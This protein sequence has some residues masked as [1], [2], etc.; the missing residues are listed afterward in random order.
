ML[1]ARSTTNSRESIWDDKSP[2]SVLRSAGSL[3]RRAGSATIAQSVAGS[4]TP[5]QRFTTQEQQ[6]SPAVTQHN[7]Q[8][9]E[10][11]QLNSALSTGSINYAAPGVRTLQEIEAEMRAQTQLA[12]TLHAQQQYLQAQQAQEEQQRQ[13]QL[14]LHH[15]HMKPPRMRSQSPFTN[16]AQSNRVQSPSIAYQQQVL[17]QREQLRME[18]LERQMRE[19]AL[20]SQQELRS[21][22][23]QPDMRDLYL[24]QAS[25]QQAYRQHQS[26]VPP[27]MDA[28]QQHQR[29]PS[30][31]SAPSVVDIQIFLQQQQQQQLAQQAAI[32]YIDSPADLARRASP[33]RHAQSQQMRLA[34]ANQVTNQHQAP[35]GAANANQMAEI[36]QIQMQQRRLAQSA[37]QE[38]SQKMD[39]GGING[40]ATGA[41][42]ANTNTQEKVKLE[43]MRRIMEAERQ[44]AKRR[45]KA[46]KIAHMVC[47][48]CFY[49][50]LF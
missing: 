9:S 25:R 16:V 18:E 29:V 8:V 10:V 48:R 42:L 13:V 44:E 43:A 19:Q 38:F 7:G 31:N 4:S 50:F 23:L 15:Q 22:Q 27:R 40:Q 36:A 33:L 47:T 45:R 2:F 11:P 24:Q 37:H 3:G 46:A 35:S 5:V 26:S 49:S 41:N 28:Q 14:Q 17:E 34:M 30:N 6:Q 20:L 32:G 12:R 21:Q 39:T 1:A